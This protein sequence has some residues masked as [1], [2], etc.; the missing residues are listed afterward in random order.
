[1]AYLCKHRHDCFLGPLPHSELGAHLRALSF[2]SSTKAS[3]E[4]LTGRPTLGPPGVSRIY[5]QRPALRRY[6]KFW[7]HSES[8]APWAL[9]GEYVVGWFPW[10]AG[11]GASGSAVWEGA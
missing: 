7:R 10:A 9:G 2:V 6:Q 1:V 8:L 3:G 5:G 11:T 4:I